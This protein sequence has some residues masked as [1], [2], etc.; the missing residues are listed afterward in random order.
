MVVLALLIL[1]WAISKTLYSSINYILKLP[2][3]LETN[4]VRVKLIAI[5]AMC[6]SVWEISQR[7]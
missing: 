6:I 7:L 3:S 4:V 5:L 2:L 1:V